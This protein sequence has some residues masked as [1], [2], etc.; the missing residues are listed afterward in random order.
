MLVQVDGH[1]LDL[2]ENIV[3]DG[4]API[5]A[6]WRWGLGLVVINEKYVSYIHG[7][8]TGA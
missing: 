3:Q 4:T 5:V 2:H 6:A 7:I 1:G 8:S